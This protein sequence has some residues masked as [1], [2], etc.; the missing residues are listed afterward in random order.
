VA[1][2]TE[3]KHPL[4]EGTKVRVTRTTDHPRAAHAST[5]FLVEDYVSATDAEDGVAFYIGSTVNGCSSVD[6]NADAI[7][8]V[9]TAEQMAA[10]ALPSMAAVRRYVGN[11]AGDV[12]GFEVNGS[13]PVGDN[14]VELHGETDDGL[15]FTVTVEIKSIVQV[16]L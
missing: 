6:A 12:D 8:I 5:E 2:T 3:I 13:E 1:T 14:L 16:D 10:R 15:P 11:L 7:E 4:P 9:M